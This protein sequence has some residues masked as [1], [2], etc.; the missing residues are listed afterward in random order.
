MSKS[1]TEKGTVLVTVYVNEINV[2][3][4]VALGLPRKPIKFPLQSYIYST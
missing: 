2:Y 1:V 4:N 3:T